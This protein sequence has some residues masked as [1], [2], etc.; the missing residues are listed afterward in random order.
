MKKNFRI[1]SFSTLAVHQHGGRPYFHDPNRHWLRI[2]ALE[3]ILKHPEDR[4]NCYN[5]RFKSK[6]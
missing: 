1:S 5:I 2:K 6:L 3:G 4:I